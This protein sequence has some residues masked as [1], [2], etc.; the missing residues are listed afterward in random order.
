MAREFG[1]CPS[2]ALSAE[3]K[4]QTGEVPALL[5]MTKTELVRAWLHP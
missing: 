2:Q 3:T 1:A 4:M 5:T